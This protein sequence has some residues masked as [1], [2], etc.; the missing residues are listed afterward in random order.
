M[1]LCLHPGGGCNEA[2]VLDA[3]RWVVLVGV[4]FVGVTRVNQER[5]S[6]HVA[7]AHLWMCSYLMTSLL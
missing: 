4:H 1:I 7:A 3:W 6:H 5:V 2:W